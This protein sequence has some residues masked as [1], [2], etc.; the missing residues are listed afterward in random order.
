MSKTFSTSSHFH[1]GEQTL[2]T[3]VGKREEIERASQLMIRTH[4][5]NQHCTFFK[6]LRYVFIGTVDKQGQPW[7]SILSGSIGFISIPNPH[8]MQIEYPFIMDHPAFVGLQP[9]S[10]VGVLGLDFS[11]RR[12]NRMNGKVLQMEANRLTI[13]VMQSYG[14]CPKYINAREIDDN[15]Q[16][17]VS[18]KIVE[19][20]H[21]NQE[22][23]VRIASADTFFIASH[24]HDGSKATYEGADISHRGGFP[25]F[26]QIGNNNTLTI[27]DYMGNFMFNTLGYL[28]TEP[29]AGLLFID[30]DTGDLTQMTGK[31]EI[32]RHEEEV[33][34]YP[35]AQRLLS[36]HIERVLYTSGGLPLRWQFLEVSPFNPFP[37]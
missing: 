12:R 36:I 11:N 30:F 27:P 31:A 29:K 5:P 17:S 4:M 25:G 16:T 13:S 6:G 19:R 32:I 8:T 10:S 20:N 18:N 3:E 26:I 21:L 1:Q 2:Q 33:N 24:H 23:C 37:S 22:D 15:Q 9:G 28:M 7:A 34:Q 14:N 35:G